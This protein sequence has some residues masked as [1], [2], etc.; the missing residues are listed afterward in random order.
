MNI[1]TNSMNKNYSILSSPKSTPVFKGYT[2]GPDEI[3]TS[4]GYSTVGPGGYV[5]GYKVPKNATPNYPGA[6]PNKYT[7]IYKADPFEIIPEEVYKTHDYTIRDDLRLSQIQKDYKNGYKNFA[8]NAENEKNFLAYNANKHREQ[9]Q[10]H[11]RL[12]DGYKKRMDFADKDSI[13]QKYS[14]KITDNEKKLAEANQKLNGYIEPLK[15]AEERFKLLKALDDKVGE[16]GAAYQEISSTGR[17]IMSCK[18]PTTE[19]DE[20]EKNLQEIK[21][22]QY[23][24]A[25]AVKNAG[26]DLPK[27]EAEEEKA[28]IKARYDVQINRI[29]ENIKNLNKKIADGKAEIPN[30]IKKCDA[31][32]EKIAQC[33]KELDVCMAN[34]EKLY[35]TKYPNW[36]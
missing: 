22:L 30:L 13:K 3:W 24:Q 31:L 21:K 36:L 8:S 15:N 28:A 29:K 27:F 1:I 16:I 26:N 2:T 4:T 19:K 23:K 10:Y 20:I 7:K 12:V 18:N 5:S 11:Q 9:S 34:V 14:V 33:Y 25:N 6:Y 17:K 35:R 32:R